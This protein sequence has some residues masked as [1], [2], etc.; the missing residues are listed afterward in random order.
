MARTATTSSRRR[1]LVPLATV[2]AAGAVAVGSGATFTSTSANTLSGVTSGTL[3]QSN[4]AD[5]RAIFNLKDVKPGDVLNGSLTITNTGT[6]PARFSLTET[7]SSN[8]FADNLRLTITD[9]TRTVYAG[10]FGGLEDG[11][12]QELGEFA[13]N[14][15]A[16]YTFTVALDAAT[17]NTYQ[18]ATA[19]ATYQWDSVQLDGATT[20]QRDGATVA[21]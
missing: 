14:Q 4:S 6:L 9:G 13:P 11:L 12:K 1:I 17:P 8:A 16:T 15:A 10:T 21:G 20:N 18:G 5:N 2:L 19:S 7:T 3:A